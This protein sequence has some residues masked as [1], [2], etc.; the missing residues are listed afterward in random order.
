V[1]PPN[2]PSCLLWVLM[3]VGCLHISA[4]NMHVTSKWFTRAVHSCGFMTA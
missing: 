1:L 2:M 3:L 4:G